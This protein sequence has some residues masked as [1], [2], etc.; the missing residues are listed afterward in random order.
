MIDK[1]NL[2]HK[3]RRP[4][5]TLKKAYENYIEWHKLREEGMS[6]DDIALKYRYTK[7]QVKHGVKRV[8]ELLPIDKGLRTM[9][10]GE[11]PVDRKKILIDSL[12][13]QIKRTLASESNYHTLQNTVK[14][15]LMLI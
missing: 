11:N 6:F 14:E 2:K 4:G 9:Y 13:V 5:I 8:T 15:L 10:Y 3:M 7:N 1:H 12:K